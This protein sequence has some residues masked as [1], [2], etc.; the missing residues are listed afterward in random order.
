MINDMKPVV[1]QRAAI[2]LRRKTGVIQRFACE[3]AYGLSMAGPACKHKRGI[4]GG[5]AGI[6][7]EHVALL[8]WSEMK[9]AV[10][11][12]DTVKC[13]VQLKGAH[14]GLDPPRLRHMRTRDFQ[15]LGRCIDARDPASFGV[16]IRGNR[17]A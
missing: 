8:F 10:P 2:V 7:A 6:Y 12:E 1:S 16:Q 13:L 4:R 5:M 3:R 15:K 9:R 17:R 11:R 14:I